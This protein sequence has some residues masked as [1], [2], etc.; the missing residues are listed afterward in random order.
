MTNPYYIATTLNS[1]YSLSTT[2]KINSLI[3][4]VTIPA[5]TSIKC[6]VSFDNK[7]NWCYHDGTGWHKYVGNL[8]QVLTN[9]N[10]NTDLQTYFTNLTITQLTSDLSN[11]GIMP[12]SL[13]LLAQL[14]TT[15]NT[16]TPILSAI[17]MQYTNIPHDE[18]ISY[19]DYS[20]MNS[21]LGIKRVNNNSI[22]VKNKT[23]SSKTIKMNLVLN[24]STSNET[25][26][27]FN[28]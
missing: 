18:F 19:G 4:P 8:T 20:D 26:G 13:D 28:L 1:N 6:L 24:G 12:T 11:L 22:I 3:I 5:N 21:M 23:T 7:T 9:Y 27:T 14:Q 15:Y 2:D 16:L 25:W 17:T 10:S